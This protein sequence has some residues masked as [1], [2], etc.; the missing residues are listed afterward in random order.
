MSSV[1]FATLA[2]HGQNP[3]TPAK[4]APIW[5]SNAPSAEARAVPLGDDRRG[6]GPASLVAGACVGVLVLRGGKRVGQKKK[7]NGAAAALQES[8]LRAGVE[9][10]EW[11]SSSN[12]GTASKV[13]V[14]LAKGNNAFCEQLRVVGSYMASPQ[15]DKFKE[16]S[17]NPDP[18]AIVV[19]CSKLDAPVNAL[20]GAEPGDLCV[21]RSLG[22]TCGRSDGVVGSIE[23][24]LSTVQPP[25]VLVL[26]NSRSE[27]VQAAV[28]EVMRAAGRDIDVPPS[29]LLLEGYK[30]E[31]LALVQKLLPAARD[32]LRTMPGAPFVKVCDAAGKLNVWSTVESLFQSPKIYDDVA[33]RRLTV[34]G[35]YI[36]VKTGKV[37][38]L[39]EH[40]AQQDLLEEGRPLDVVRTAS[41]PPVPPQE[42]LCSLVVGNRR[43]TK[44]GGGGQL[45]SYVLKALAGKGQLPAAVVLGCADSRAPVE[46]YFDMQPGDLFV[47]RTAG[48]T[49]EGGFGGLLGSAEYAIAVLKTKLIVV[50]GHTLCGAVT[51]TVK[52]VKANEGMPPDNMGVVLD[53]IRAAAEM[54]VKTLSGAPL[55]QQLKLAT[56]LNIFEAMQKMMRHSKILRD[57]I[58]SEELM[59]V[60]AV[61]NIEEGSVEWLG[62]HPEQESIVGATLH[63]HRWRQTPYARK[64]MPPSTSDAREII[65]RLR[66]GNTRFSENHEMYGVHENPSISHDVEPDTVLVGSSNLRISYETVFDSKPGQI[67]AQK[68]MGNIAGHA[69]GAMFA[70]LEFA[71]VRFAPKVLVVVG[72]L[73]DE[74][75]SASLEQI[76]GGKMTSKSMR[77]V[78]DQIAPSCLKAVIDSDRASAGETRGGRRM[79]IEQTATELNALYTIEQI[80][81]HSPIIRDAAKNRGLELHAAILDSTTG[82]VDFVG[83]HPLVEYL[84]ARDISIKENAH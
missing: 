66:E 13:L 2:G 78:L 64:S 9:P 82:K 45:E 67:I 75:V 59:L 31:D 49:I 63:L 32:A 21:V 36:D 12:A 33:A 28:R 58:A 70:S 47:L 81:T 18:K 16:L 37:Q 3:T 56:K 84:L 40:R 24:E 39:G 26:G 5:Q 15:V 51:A 8:E 73:G 4:L 11:R 69:G 19:C 43:Y 29:K 17:L 61:Y 50:T 68:C 23:Y 42:A 38:F 76:R 22:N 41:D 30:E 79:Q 74:V 35:A 44:G 6:H 55:E 48:N 20:F 72:H 53:N 14:Q 62:P 1:G 83:Q 52:A 77:Y 10:K 34:Q 7:K 71:V 80:L 54:S 46:I 60:G 27:A 65:D 57:G 25:L